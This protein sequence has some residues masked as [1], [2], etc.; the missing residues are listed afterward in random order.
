MYST[1]FLASKNNGEAKNIPR[2]SIIKLL[3][4]FCPSYFEI[5]ELEVVL[6]GSELDV[7]H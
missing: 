1:G 2:Y 7:F 6:S 5:G 3:E 4:S